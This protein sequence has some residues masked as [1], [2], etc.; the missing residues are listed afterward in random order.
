VPLTYRIDHSRRLVLVVAH[1]V[2]SPDDMFNYQREVWSRTEV[3]GYAELVDMTEVE[4][5]GN[6]S[7]ARIHSL[8]KLAAGM[9]QPGRSAKFAI[10]APQDEIYGLG[11]MYEAYRDSIP[12]STKR[13]AVFR[14]RESALAWLA[15]SGEQ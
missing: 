8:A 13:V 7:A 5:L 3:V 14:D 1:G 9:D 10:V 4:E 12:E 6:P 15:E 2:L 11:R